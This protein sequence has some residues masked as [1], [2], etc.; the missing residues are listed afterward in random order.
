MVG[1]AAQRE[2]AAL[3]A[4]MLTTW[5]LLALFLFWAVGAYNRLIRLRSAAIQA[6]GG[7][8]THMVRW[9]ALLTEYEAARGSPDVLRATPPVGGHDN[10]AAL[11]AAATQFG[12]SLAVA[13]A[14]PLDGGAAAALAAAAQVLETAWQSVLREA[15]QASEGVA[16]PALAPWVQRREQVALLRD[17]AQR[18]FNEAVVQYNQAI[19]QFPAN[20]LAWL[21]GFKKAQTL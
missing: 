5:I 12:A 17:P 13:R 21:F 1:G 14:R 20:L 18:L 15:A 6:F 10:H 16:P 11:W 8:D 9:I 19:A 2:R 7:L 4:I 3:V